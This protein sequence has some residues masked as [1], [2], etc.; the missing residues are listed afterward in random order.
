M[1][2]GEAEHHFDWMT[3]LVGTL[4]GV[5]GLALSWWM[6]AEPSPVPARLAQQLRPL[7][8]ASYHKFGID[9]FYD[10]VVI[11]PT[12]LLASFLRFF[13][14]YFVDNLIVRGTAWLPRTIGRNLLAPFQNGLIQFYAA[15]TA[16]S[17]ALLLL[18]LL[19]AG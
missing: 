6:Y 5:A 19:F 18:V 3:A 4:V 10:W 7:Y 14:Y 8:E 11:G 1:L 17:V 2:G 12:R 13:D 16:A 15:V 9:T